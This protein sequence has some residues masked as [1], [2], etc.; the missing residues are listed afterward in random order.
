M[1]EILGE[2]GDK[3]LKYK[4]LLVHVEHFLGVVSFA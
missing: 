1:F 2:C 3:Y 4:A